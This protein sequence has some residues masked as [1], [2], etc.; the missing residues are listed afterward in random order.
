MN[1]SQLAET[2]SAELATTLEF[3]RRR[4]IYSRPDPSHGYY[5]GFSYDAIQVS[6][7]QLRLTGDILQF[8]DLSFSDLSSSHGVVGVSALD[9][10][11][12]CFC[13]M[14]NPFIH[15]GIDVPAGHLISFSPERDY[16]YI[17]GDN[18][19]S[20]DITVHESLLQDQG[21]QLPDPRERTPEST[22]FP[23]S[24]TILRELE[25]IST[26]S[27]GPGNIFESG[28]FSGPLALAMRENLLNLLSRILSER[29]YL[30]IDQP[31]IKKIARFDLV[32]AAMDLIEIGDYDS[33]TVESIANA[34]GVTPRAIQYAFRN[35]GLGG[36]AQYILARKLN[37]A[38]LDLSAVDRSDISVTQAAMDNGF[39]NLGRFSDYYRKLFGELPSQTLRNATEQTRAFTQ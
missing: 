16:H 37:Q 33:M 21:L 17:T 30:K 3:H 39:T 22:V 9:P 19:K 34:L 7:G 38:R 2:N 14:R 25:M 11:W 13:V 24:A 5:D 4:V 1:N 28:L 36:P 12:H 23:I 35:S 18:A 20:F 26:V 6:S 8:K 32:M 31:S 10:G 29:N 27:F 15:C